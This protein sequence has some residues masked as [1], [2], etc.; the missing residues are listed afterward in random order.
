MTLD[1]GIRTL[2]GLPATIPDCSRDELPLFLRDRGC[3]VGAE[4][5][6]YKGAFTEKFCKVGLKMYAIDPWKAFPGQG[7]TQMIQD[8]QDFLFGHATRTL[9]KYRHCAIIRDTSVGAL[10]QFADQ[11]LDFVYIDGDH[12]FHR[13]AE[14]VVE[15]TKKVKRG[16]IISGHDYFCTAPEAA[17][18]VCHVGP[19]IDAWVKVRGIKNF[20]VFGR[21]KPIE[22]EA[23]DDKYLSWLWIKE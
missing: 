2:K 3:K 1:E 5:G 10:S 16:G 6:V 21:S 14:D 13:V 15:W 8:R 7:R 22:Q 17:N 20:W 12:V 9:S 19:V 23:K 4:I 11:S 18:T